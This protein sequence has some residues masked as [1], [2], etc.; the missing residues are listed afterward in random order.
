MMKRCEE[1]P[2]MDQNRGS[3]VTEARFGNEGRNAA[4]EH[5]VDPTGVFQ[6][7]ISNLEV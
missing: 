5:S 4:D 1:D 2:A 7:A 3:K 6:V